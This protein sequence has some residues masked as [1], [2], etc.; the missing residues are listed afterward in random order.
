MGVLECTSYRKRYNTISAN[1]TKGSVYG[2]QIFLPQRRS[3]LGPLAPEVSVQSVAGIK[4]PIFQFSVFGL[5]LYYKII[6]KCDF[7]TIAGIRLVRCDSADQ[8]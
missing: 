3:N 7:A 8:G 2:H 4:S 5:L 1:E 6:F